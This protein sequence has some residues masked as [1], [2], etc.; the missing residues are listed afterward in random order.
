MEDFKKAL[1]EDVTQ[2]YAAHKA[3]K[4]A[5]NVFNWLVEM[6]VDSD[7]AY[8]YAKYRDYARIYH[9][10]EFTEAEKAEFKNIVHER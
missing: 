9:S 3:A 10:K 5:F 8:R 1:L 7:K 2:A 6:G 4:V